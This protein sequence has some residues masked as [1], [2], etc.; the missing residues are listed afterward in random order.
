MLA[1]PHLLFNVISPSILAI[2]H[3]HASLPK[4][5]TTQRKQHIVQLWALWMQLA[6]PLKAQGI[7]ISIS[8]CY[9][10]EHNIPHICRVSYINHNTTNFRF[11]G[12][13]L[14]AIIPSC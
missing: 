13:L 3:Q 12:N 2:L 1:E 6:N 14:C 7:V 5:I 11:S 4:V 10:A 9:Q 8:W